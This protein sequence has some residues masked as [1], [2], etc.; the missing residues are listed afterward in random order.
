MNARDRA[1]ELL[2]ELPL[3]KAQRDLYEAGLAKMSDDEV[4]ASVSRLEEALNRA[5]ETL[6]AARSLLRPKPPRP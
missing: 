1:K 4:A 6:E 3:S 5:P 2:Q